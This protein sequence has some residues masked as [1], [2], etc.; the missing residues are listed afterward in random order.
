MT[1]RAEVLVTLARLQESARRL[2]W[3]LHLAGRLRQAGAP[4]HVRE[5]A[6]AGAVG[7]AFRLDFAWPERRFAVE[8]NGGGWMAPDP[9]GNRRG[10]HGGGEALERDCE[11]LTLAAALGWRVGAVTPAQIK[12]GRAVAWIL[13]ALEVEQPAEERDLPEERRARLSRAFAIKDSAAAWGVAPVVPA[14]DAAPV[15]AR[16]MG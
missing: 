5:Y 3:E 7:R 9:D 1:D 8:V 10:A 12:D 2:R 4:G 13:A 6:F 15:K 14:Q 11:K 16:V